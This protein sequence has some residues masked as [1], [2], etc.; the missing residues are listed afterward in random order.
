[1]ME[2]LYTVKCRLNGAPRELMVSARER[3]VSFGLATDHKEGGK[4]I[5]LRS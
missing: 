2:E 3:M 5:I 1:M 4:Y